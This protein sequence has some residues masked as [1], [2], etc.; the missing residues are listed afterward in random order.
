MPYHFSRYL[1]NDPCKGTSD[2]EIKHAG[3]LE[4]QESVI[5]SQGVNDYVPL[6]INSSA[7]LHLFP[8]IFNVGRDRI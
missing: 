4:G 1:N 3:K 7:F 8:F 6:K 5:M 2:L